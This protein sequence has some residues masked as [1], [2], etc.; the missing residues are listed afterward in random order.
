M[1]RLVAM[2]VRMNQIWKIRVDL[3]FRVVLEW[4]CR[5]S[6]TYRLTLVATLFA[7]LS[8]VGSRAPSRTR[9]TD[10]D[11]VEVAEPPLSGGDLVIVKLQS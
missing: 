2:T 11:A 4:T 6:S 1:A 9:V 3:G 7:E 8:R 10:R 5:C